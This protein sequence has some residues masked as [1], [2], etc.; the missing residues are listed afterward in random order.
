MRVT[1]SRL[2]GVLL[3]SLV[4]PACDSDRKGIVTP[5]VSVV[6]VTVSPPAVSILADS[7]AQLRAVA[8]GSNQTELT[9]AQIVWASSD[10]TI[11]SVDATGLVRGR[12]AG[13][14]TVTAASGGKEGRASIT[15]SPRP[16][17]LSIVAINGITAAGADTIRVQ[18]TLSVRVRFVPDLSAAS[19]EAFLVRIGS[20]GVEEILASRILSS[21]GVR[22][23]DLRALSAP[24]GRGRVLIRLRAGTTISESNAV[25]VALARPADAVRILAINGVPVDTLSSTAV[26]DSFRIRVRVTVAD[27]SQATSRI[28]IDEMRSGWRT[29]I[30]RLEQGFQPGTTTDTTFTTYIARPGT[31]RIRA[32]LFTQSS[33]QRVFSPYY[34]VT[35]TQSD[36]SPPTVALLAPAHGSTVRTRRVEVSW[37][38]SD[39]RA[40]WHY[41]IR[42]LREDTCGVSTVVPIPTSLSSEKQ[43]ASLTSCDLNPGLN[44]INLVVNDVSGNETIVPFSVTYAP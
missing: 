11:A 40:T 44:Q 2:I 18:D 43:R 41:A 24:S 4:L 17:S 36:I 16:T 22:E 42:H 1:V 38:M 39:N 10:S 26:A 13:S 31:D 29:Q 20:S 9:G 7:T 27:A 37:E 25:P 6:S 21:G 28:F 5:S 12:R 23:I 15:V 34:P 35:V 14:A 3:T 8:M 30:G 19:G 32:D 33:F